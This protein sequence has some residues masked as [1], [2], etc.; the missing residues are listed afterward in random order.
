MTITNDI[1]VFEEADFQ[2]LSPSLRRAIAFRAGVQIPREYLSIR[3]NAIL[4]ESVAVERA[5][6]L[7]DTDVQDVSVAFF[8]SDVTTQNQV[9]TLL[10][11]P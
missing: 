5:A 1:L 10:G 4:Q 9:K 8:R 11:I 2:S 6:S 7:E 3:F